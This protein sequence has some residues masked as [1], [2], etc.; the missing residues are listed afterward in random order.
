MGLNGACKRPSHQGRT[1]GRGIPA[2]AV[3][4][5]VSGYTRNDYPQWAMFRAVSEL[6]AYI[7][8]RARDELDGIAEE[9]RD[10]IYVV[11]FFV[12]CARP[13]RCYADFAVMP[14]CGRRREGG[15]VLRRGISPRRDLLVDEKQG[16]RCCPVAV[17]VGG[18]IDVSDVMMMVDLREVLGL[19]GW[20][21]SNGPVDP[22]KVSVGEKLGSCA[23][24]RART[25]RM[26]AEPMLIGIKTQSGPR[27]GL[28]A[29][30]DSIRRCQIENGRSVYL[31]P[32]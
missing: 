20:A 10:N 28:R 3:R 22:T 30:A 19:A 5:M 2:A 9:E 27:P 17:G 4:R 15:N 6:D 18:R 12:Q 7:F 21:A 13:H 26:S 16:C 1:S 31:R 11:S 23:G 14:M 8:D 25:P 24:L 29:E 32:V